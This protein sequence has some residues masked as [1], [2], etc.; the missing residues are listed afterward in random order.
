MSKICVVGAGAI[1]GYVGAHFAANGID[2]TLIDAWAEHVEAMRRTGLRVEGVNGA[3]SVSTP[4]NALHIGDVPQLIRTD[5]FDIVFI[6]V[7]S[8][9]TLWA[10]Q[11]ILPY[12]AASGCIV[13]LQNSIN[14]D[15]IASVAGWSRT[16]GCSLS[17]IASELVAPGHIVRN[18]PLGDEVKIGLRIG[19]VHGR[20]TP[21]AHEIARLLSCADSAKVT[22]I[23]G[24]SV[25]RSSSSTRCATVYRP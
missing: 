25:G 17:T 11:L 24:A 20:S 2:V 3:G 13:S 23:Y 7:K 12:M 6:A 16:L 18:S 1:G 22:A 21:R 5:P 8:Y 19:E 9:D 10:T 15:A 4:V 14:E